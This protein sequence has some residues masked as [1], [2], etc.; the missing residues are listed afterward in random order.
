MQSIRSLALFSIAYLLV[1]CSGDN[2]EKAASG[3]VS[4]AVEL[5]KGAATGASKGVEEGRKASTSIDGA[6]IVSSGDELKAAL[7]GTVLSADKDESARVTLGFANDG[8]A[9]VRVTELSQGN[10]VTGLDSE[11]YAC[12]TVQAVDEF[13]VPAKAK[14]K[15]EFGFQCTGKALATVRLYD[16]EYAVA[17]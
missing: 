1:A 13:T 15:V 2:A 5:A 10:H 17:R 9:P 3:A 7:T 12:S 4:K 6:V 14:L 16:V 8:D 11:G